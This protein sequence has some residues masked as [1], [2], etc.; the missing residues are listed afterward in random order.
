[1]KRLFSLLP[2]AILFVVTVSSQS[3][4]MDSWCARFSGVSRGSLPGG[5]DKLNSFLRYSNDSAEGAAHTL[6]IFLRFVNDQDLKS[7]LSASPDE[8]EASIANAEKEV[9]AR[10]A[11]GFDIS[12]MP[13]PFRQGSSPGALGRDANSWIHVLVTEGF[14][15]SY[16]LAHGQQ[17]GALSN[18]EQSVQSVKAELQSTKTV[19]RTLGEFDRKSIVTQSILAK[20]V[21]YQK[22][23]LG[24]LAGLGMED[25]TGAV[26]KLEAAAGPLGKL[27]ASR[28]DLGNVFSGSQDPTLFAV[29]RLSKILSRQSLS[30]KTVASEIDAVKGLFKDSTKVATIA[31]VLSPEELSSIQSLLEVASTDLSAFASEISAFKNAEDEFAANGSTTDTDTMGAAIGFVNLGIGMLGGRQSGELQSLSKAMTTVADGIA[32]V[33]TGA[34]LVEGTSSLL[35]TINSATSMLTL[36]SPTSLVAGGVLAI[37]AGFSQHSEAK[38]LKKIEASVQAVRQDIAAMKNDMDKR[39]DRVDTMIG[40][41]QSRMIEEFA[42][43]DLKLDRMIEEIDGIR[44]YLIAGDLS[45]ATSTLNELDTAAASFGSGLENN[46][47]RNFRARW[48]LRNGDYQTVMTHFSGLGPDEPT[49]SDPLR[50]LYSFGISASG[51]EAIFNPIY[52]LALLDVFRKLSPYISSKDTELYL[53]DVQQ[54]FSTFMPTEALLGTYDYDNIQSEISKEIDALDAAKSR[55]E[56]LYSQW[57]QNDVWPQVKLQH[58]TGHEGQPSDFVMSLYNNF[59]LASPKRFFEQLMD[60]QSNAG[61]QSVMAEVGVDLGSGPA[62]QVFNDGR[63]VTVPVPF[64]FLKELGLQDSDYLCFS[65]L[66]IELT[67]KYRG[68]NVSHQQRPDGTFSTTARVDVDMLLELPGHR[69]VTV[70]GSLPGLLW[71]GDKPSEQQIRQA[72]SRFAFFMT[73]PPGAS[74]WTPWDHYLDPSSAEPQII[75]K[76]PYYF[77]TSLIQRFGKEVA[78]ADSQQGDSLGLKAAVAGLPQLA[79]ELFRI[80]NDK[81]DTDVGFRSFLE[82]ISDSE[83]SNNTVLTI[84]I[85]GLS[86][87][88]YLEQRLSQERQDLSFRGPAKYQPSSFIKEGIEICKSIC[89]ELLS[90]ATDPEKRRRIQVYSGFFDTF[91]ASATYGSSVEFTD[92]AS[93]ANSHAGD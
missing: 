27:V 77:D 5:S 68:Y 86:G 62:P 93:Y 32:F 65:S 76:Q 4:D 75:R 53:S 79:V 70:P 60:S 69:T 43:T 6:S 78:A 54:A 24:T 42:K 74:K 46:Y 23:A 59:S 64:L 83:R 11:A 33:Q 21:P 50:F 29:T 40:D 91:V 73:P 81:W 92:F 39:F 16:E 45:R 44:K 10:A 26:S 8:L 37:A 18:I 49:K 15:I 30:A 28:G 36:V 13:V 80:D 38:E 88:A 35:G 66:P 1:M 55:L 82:V 19:E 85:D 61:W 89:S 52:W 25:P 7:V 48:L 87:I 58:R 47:V 3:T 31:Q 57:F 67:F 41:I 12:L 2:F 90:N 56:P 84:D 20:L 22:D 51:K 72:I 63:D 71:T 9:L 34:S 14:V 17:P